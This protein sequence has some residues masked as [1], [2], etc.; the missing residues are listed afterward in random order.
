MQIPTRQIAS[1]AVAELADAADLKSAALRGM[2]VQIPPA[3]WQGQK[4]DRLP[5]GRAFSF[6]PDEATPPAHTGGVVVPK[7]ETGNAYPE[8]HNP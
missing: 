6:S 8:Y 4:P 7:K 3:A 2:R 1:A 5:L